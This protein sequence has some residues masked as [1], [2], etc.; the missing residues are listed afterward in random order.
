MVPG[1]SY[2]KT[3]WRRKQGCLAATLWYQFGPYKWGYWLHP[4]ILAW[5]IAVKLLHPSYR[6]LTPPEI[7]GLHI[8]AKLLQ[9]VTWSLLATYRNLT[10]DAVSNS[11]VTDRCAMVQP[12]IP[13]G[14]L[15][16]LNWG[17]FPTQNACCLAVRSAILITAGFHF[18]VL[19]SVQGQ[20]RLYSGLMHFQQSRTD[21]HQSAFR[22]QTLSGLY[23]I[24]FKL[25]FLE[26]FD[27]ISHKKT[28]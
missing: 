22:V 23:R 17:F 26:L 7:L 20:C 2:R 11:T 14:H 12:M 6:Y 10:I 24:Y 4:Q 8:A 13:S 3:V 15:F 27:Q 1:T 21:I 16:F 5:W 25:L 9:I 19:Y 28:G 18:L